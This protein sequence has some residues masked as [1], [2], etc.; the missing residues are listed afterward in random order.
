MR[1]REPSRTLRSVVTS[2]RTRCRKRSPLE[3]KTNRCL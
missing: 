3:R 2:R 1:A